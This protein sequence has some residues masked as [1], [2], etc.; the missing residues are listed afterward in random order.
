MNYKEKLYSNLK[1]ERLEALRELVKESGKKIENGYVNLHIHTN[2]SFSVFRSPTEAVW[3]AFNSNIEYYGIND[4]YSIDG[5]PEFQEACSI[6]GIKAV[7]GIEAMA[8]NEELRKKGIRLNDPNNPGRNYLVGKGIVRDLQKGS[9]AYKIFEGIKGAIQLRNKRM[10]ECINR[11]F[12]ENGY[13]I[14]FSYNDVVSLTPHGNATERH[15]VQ[16]V[17][18]KIES[19]YPDLQ[20]QIE[21]Y[22]KLLGYKFTEEELKDIPLLHAIVREKLVKSGA[23]CY[24]EEDKEAFT[25]LENMIMIF[26]EYGAIPIY[27]ILGKP[28]TE[29]EADIEKLIM[30][31]KK[32]G[33]Y[34]FDIFDHRIDYN[35]AKEIIDVAK[36]HGFP[37]FIGTEHN[38]K[39]MMPLIGILGKNE[40]F[41]D[42][43]RKSARFVRGH[44]VLSVLCNY[45]FLL[46]NGKPRFE[47]LH[48]GFDFY[49][50]IGGKELSDEELKEMSKKT[51]EEN[52]KFFGI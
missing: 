31:V 52:R 17:C 24:V 21:V 32:I 1:S 38:T 7:F 46:E 9:K 6:A 39:K 15:V 14:D 16:A 47:D 22:N 3:E 45:G 12:K 25:S 49:A 28:V 41:L 30:E 51:I 23:P 50:E 2:E 37:V 27:P 36:E 5:H 19:I 10:A 13:D 8:M 34:A 29:W 33:L 18:E 43:F 42:Y 20:Q 40:E 4:H 35:R 44:Q 48:E 26:R 11:Y